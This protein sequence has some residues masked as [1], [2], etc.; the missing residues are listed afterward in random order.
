MY[1]YYLW[2]DMIII[3]LEKKIFMVIG[4]IGKIIIVGRVNSGIWF[5]LNII[6]VIGY[7]DYEYS[8]FIEVCRVD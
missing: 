8:I 2:Y 7:Y 6:F 5:Y 3:D 4:N 1:V